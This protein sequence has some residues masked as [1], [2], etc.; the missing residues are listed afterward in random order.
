MA[1]IL[2]LLRDV[3]SGAFDFVPAAVQQHARESLDRAVTCLLDAQV[4]VEGVRTVW[5]AQH[6]PLTLV[7]VKARAYEHAS[8]S[9]S[10]SVSLVD[11]LMGIEPAGAR[12]QAAVQAAAAWFRANAI[13]GYDYPPDRERV[14]RA[15]AGPLWARFYEIGTNRP[16]FSNRDG[17]VRY[18][19]HELG[20]ERRHGYAWYTE[21]PAALL[22]RCEAWARR[23]D[24]DAPSP[25]SSLAR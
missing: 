25:Q 12:E 3:A 13:Y 2:M 9:G 16:I 18:D 21:R 20:E 5:G 7:P 19:W 11:F 14:E 23:H 6:D 15:G 10:E 1:G 17:V 22:A 24:C 4:R 8:L